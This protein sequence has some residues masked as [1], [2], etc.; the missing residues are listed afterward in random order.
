MVRHRDGGCEPC[1]RTVDYVLRGRSCV[2]RAGLKEPALG[3]PTYREVPPSGACSTAAR[4]MRT[5]AASEDLPWPDDSTA[6][7]VV[8]DFCDGD[9][10]G[11]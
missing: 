9:W 1:V 2:G 3:G 6:Q 4:P 7:K 8:V 5:P 11:Q 10:P